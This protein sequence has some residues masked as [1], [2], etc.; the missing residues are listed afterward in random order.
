MIAHQTKLEK[1][2]VPAVESISSLKKFQAIKM[3]AHGNTVI[4][5]TSICHRIKR[6]TVHAES[7]D[8]A[9]VTDF[10]SL[11][12]S[13]II[14]K[15][16]HGDD[17]TSATREY[18]QS[19]PTIVRDHQ[20]AERSIVPAAKKVLSLKRLYIIRKCANGDSVVTAARANLQVKF[21]IVQKSRHHGPASALAG[22]AVKDSRLIE[23]TS[24]P[25]N[26]SLRNA[27]VAR[28][29]NQRVRFTTVPGQH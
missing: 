12:K 29:R 20:Q 17:V 23:L 7:G 5:A 11:E 22:N 4:T 10:L 8:V 25:K 21:M 27:S 19:K 16:A 13:F 3:H 1:N 6:M 2:S 28:S 18:H 24:T 26:A 9:A 14:K 15:H